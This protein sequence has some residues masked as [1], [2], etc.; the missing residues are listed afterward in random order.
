M[1]IQSKTASL[2]WKALIVVIGLVGIAIGSGMLSGNLD[3]RAFQMF[4]TLSNLLA[5]VYFFMAL[6]VLGARGNGAPTFAPMVKQIVTMGVTVTF[7]IAH[8]ML[9]NLLFTDGVLNVDMLILHYIV[10]IMSILDWLLFDEK[11]KMPA[12]A[13]FAWLVLPIIYLAASEVAVNVC[14]L[15]VG[16]DSSTHGY[17]YPFLDAVSL[18]WPRVIG[19]ICLM[20]AAFLALGYVWRAIDSLLARAGRK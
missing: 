17:P 20:V 14:G 18:G 3:P 6:V 7:L 12:F 9:F 2:V 4:T 16:L 11:G 5:I 8:F 10:P 13:P 15:S 19:F 1:R